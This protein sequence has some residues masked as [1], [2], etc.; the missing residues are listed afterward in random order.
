MELVFKEK[1]APGVIE[2]NYEELRAEIAEAVKQYTNLAYTDDQMTEAKADRAK[3]RKFADVLESARKQVKAECLA[4]YTAFEQQVKE[5]VALID[6]PVRMIDRQVKEY[7]D[8]LKVEKEQK[9][10]KYYQSLEDRPKDLALS[11]I[12]NDRWL[13]VT[14]S[15][16]KIEEEITQGIQRFNA[17][18]AVIE[19]L[20]NP[21]PARM[22]Y[23]DTMDLNRAIAESDRQDA[24]ELQKQA[25]EQKA[26]ECQKKVE[27]QKAQAP[28]PAKEV[29][30]TWIAFKAYL[31]V[32]E[33]ARLKYF[34]EQN[35]IEFAP[36]R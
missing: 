35:Q 1:M 8:R 4:P 21:I 17:E 26:I 15:M 13:N 11:K 19:R 9:V 33:A 10:I 25:E 20:K 29:K 6:E 32:E 30:R 22:V 14:Y 18:M 12:W 31:S 36:V 28:A 23:I 27:E 34:F 7:E 3:L 5:L 24:I 16:K 2:F